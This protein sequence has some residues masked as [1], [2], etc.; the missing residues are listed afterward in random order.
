MRSMALALFPADG[1]PDVARYSAREI[2]D[3]IGNAVAA[4][5]QIVGPELEYLL[6]DSGQRILPAGLHLVDGSA[7]VGAKHVGKPIDLDLTQSVPHRALDD[8]GSELD[9]IVF[10]ETGRLAE[11]LD[12]RAFL[13][14]GRRGGPGMLVGL[15]RF[16]QR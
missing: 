11:L 9:L 16:L 10:G 12:Q 3:L 5:L 7:P 8:A 6:R 2:D 1:D 13:G 15:F 14:F 4:R